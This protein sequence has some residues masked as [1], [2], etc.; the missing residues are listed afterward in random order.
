MKEFDMAAL[1]AASDKIA[2][3]IQK[4]NVGSIQ[5]SGTTLKEKLHQE[6]L[7]FAV[8]LVGSDGDITDEEVNVIKGTLNV[9]V[10]RESLKATKR[11]EH[12]DYLD[13]NFRK[14]VPSSIKYAV[15]A[16]AAKKLDPDPYKGQK[17]MMFYDT[18][19]L[20]GQYIMAVQAKEAD[21]VTL[22]CFT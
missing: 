7:M 3:D 17:A 16:D 15:L 19:K 9:E 6:L 12:I 20:F 5:A 22:S 10:T 18:F 11:R 21:V 8:F 13:Y 14:K 1:M 2:D 4:V